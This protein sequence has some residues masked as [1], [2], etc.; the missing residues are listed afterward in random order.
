MAAPWGS[1]TFWQC[2]EVVVSANR[3]LTR[4]QSLFRGRHAVVSTASWVQK[5]VVHRFS[6]ASFWSAWLAWLCPWKPELCCTKWLNCLLLLRRTLQRMSSW[7][8]ASD[9]FISTRATWLRQT[10]IALHNLLH[11]ES[12]A[13]FRFRKC[14]LNSSGSKISNPL[15][16]YFGV[17]PQSPPRWSLRITWRTWHQKSQ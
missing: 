2:L 10:C 13:R 1:S 5:I 11:C 3:S 9:R 14:K 4:L 12:L 6:R 7:K 17:G 16:K 15:D 8:S